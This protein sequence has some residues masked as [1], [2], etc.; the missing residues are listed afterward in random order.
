MRQHTVI[1]ERIIAAAPRCARSA[2]I[3]RSSHER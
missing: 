3:V 2:A 1:G